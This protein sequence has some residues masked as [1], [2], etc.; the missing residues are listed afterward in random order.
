MSKLKQKHPIT[1]TSCAFFSLFPFCPDDFLKK[2]SPLLPSFPNLPH[3][4]SLPLKKEGDWQQQCVY[5][6]TNLRNNICLFLYVL[7]RTL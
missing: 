1:P 2:W 6:A 7:V 5:L 4:H 3:F